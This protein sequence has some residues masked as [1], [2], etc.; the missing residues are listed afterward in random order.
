MHGRSQIQSAFID[1]KSNT[2]RSIQFLSASVG[3]L[4][5]YQDDQGREKSAVALS[6]DQSSFK[7]TITLDAESAPGTRVTVTSANFLGRKA[8]Q[9]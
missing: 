8:V 3:D 6:C 2:G 5:A 4:I 1:P 9:Q 7:G